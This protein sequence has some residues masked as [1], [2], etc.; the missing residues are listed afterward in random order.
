MP[1]ESLGE[2]S[3]GISEDVE[4]DME[5]FPEF[6]KYASIGSNYPINESIISTLVTSEQAREDVVQHFEMAQNQS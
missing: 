1:I 6:E 3:S 2:I 4:D 5:G